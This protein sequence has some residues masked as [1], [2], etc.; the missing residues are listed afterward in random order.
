MKETE[1]ELVAMTK[2]RNYNRSYI[3]SAISCMAPQTSMN[4]APFLQG[5]LAPDCVGAIDD[6]DNV[7]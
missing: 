2:N 7:N 6:S 5:R 3:S 1:I 4:S